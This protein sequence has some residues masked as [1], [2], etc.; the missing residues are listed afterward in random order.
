MS[1]LYIGLSILSPHVVYFPW[2]FLAIGVLF[3]V[4]GLIIHCTYNFISKIIFSAVPIITGIILLW[5]CLN[6]IHAF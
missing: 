6:D 4:W 5:K 1:A 2:A 3:I